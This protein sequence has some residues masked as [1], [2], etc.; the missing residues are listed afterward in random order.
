MIFE[1]TAIFYY[2]LANSLS[3]T[4]LYSVR[5]DSTWHLPLLACPFLAQ[6]TGF[7]LKKEKSTVCINSV[8]SSWLLIFMYFSP[9]YYLHEAS[10]HWISSHFS[11]HW[12]LLRWKSRRDCEIF[13]AFIWLF[14]LISRAKNKPVSGQ[15]LNQK[16]PANCT[17]CESLKPYPFWSIKR[18]SYIWDSIKKGVT[19]NQRRAF[20]PWRRFD[21][22]TGQLVDEQFLAWWMAL[23]SQDLCS[24]TTAYQNFSLVLQMLF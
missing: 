4:K 16:L 2:L 22:R 12:S 11:I 8:Y 15:K 24:L 6:N 13:F 9:L 3:N 20:S 21:F 5:V 10:E 23:T 7:I 18:N 1:K 19:F 14:S 17:V